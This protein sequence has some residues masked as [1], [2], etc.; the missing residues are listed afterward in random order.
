MGLYSQDH[1]VYTNSKGFEIPSVTTVLHIINKPALPYWANGL[2]FKHIKVKD[3]LESRAAVGTD[4]HDMI[5]KYT[6]GIDINGEHLND[7]IELFETFV[8]WSDKNSYKVAAS[9]QQLS[10]EEF[11]GTIDAI[12]HIN[13]TLSMVDYKTAKAIYPTMFLQLAG[14]SLSVKEN[15]P[16]TYSR[17]KQYGILS[18]SLK[19]G[20]RT[21]FV[22]K[23][24]LEDKYVPA[25]KQALKLFT[26]W[27]R[28]NMEDWNTNIAK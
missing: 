2:G 20:I 17:I 28:I 14:Y 25:F 27:F 12:G 3:E 24:E 21:K 23:E 8:E 7:A 19:N 16:E 18:I 15:M 6:T 26:T 10:C 1:T 4:L 9:E 11:G 22:S 5:S 13:G